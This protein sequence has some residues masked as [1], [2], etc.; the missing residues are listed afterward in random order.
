[1]TIS[2]Q[3]L[4]RLIDDDADLLAATRQSLKLA[5]FQVEAFSDPQLAL[6]GL[7]PAYPGVVL[8]DVRMPGMDGLEVFAELR[9]RD[10]ELPV[11]LMTGNGD[12]DM[13]VNAM[14]AGAW[15]FLTKPVGFDALTQ[16]LKRACAAR[17]LVIE[18]R[19]LRAQAHGDD[20]AGLVG[21][22]PAIIALRAA[23]T[24]L[25]D[26]AI[27]L[28][29]SGPT[30]AGKGALARAIHDAG[31]RRHKGFVH[32]AC[33]ALEEST[34]TTLLFGSAP[35]GNQPRQSGRIEPADRGTL[36]L[37]RIEFLSLGMQARILHVIERQAFWPVGASAARQIDMRVIAATSVDLAQMVAEG[38]F[39]SDL[40]YRL[41]GVGLHVPA[42]TERRGDIA[43]LYRHF[44]I[45][46]ARQHKRP[47]PEVTP[48]VQA[49]LETHDWPGNARE[50]RQFAQGQ[51][52]GLAVDAA[53]DE[54][55]TLPLPEMVARYEA[56]LLRQALTETKG[57]V[58]K[59]IDKLGLPRKTFYDK[60]ARHGLQPD[61][62]RPK[63]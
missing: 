52:L 8:T 35:Q 46:A 33:D 24:R 59:A 45:E 28:L 22:S 47:V 3:A 39:N 32:I 26:T 44:L 51:I 58:A 50:L 2:P 15:D 37:D 10:P 49:R 56:A 18:N 23:V 34:A 42:L 41:S 17:D 57:H 12:I 54:G 36:F 30:G 25:G 27:E 21:N 62:F 1:M 20:E 11:I 29:I 53:Q 9:A 19:M 38:R 6:E 60:L 14:R 5:G 40:Y 31:A 43:P 48:A 13:A 63:A 4:V 16:A 55:E 61:A 7:G